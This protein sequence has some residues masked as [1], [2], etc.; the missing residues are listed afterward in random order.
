MRPGAWGT[1]CPPTHGSGD[2]K[3]AFRALWSVE[4]PPPGPRPSPRQPVWMDG[5]GLWCG[6]KAKGG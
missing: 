4:P 1:S 6:L 3:L 5:E 2:L